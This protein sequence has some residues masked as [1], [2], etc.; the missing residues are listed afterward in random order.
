MFTIGET[1][2]L[3]DAIAARMSI[4]AFDPVDIDYETV[5]ELAYAASRAASRNNSQSWR[6]IFVKGKDRLY[7]LRETLSP[8]NYWAKR[9]SM[10]VAVRSRPDLDCR[11]GG[12]D[13]N[14]MDTGMALSQLLLSAV[15]LGLS[16]HPVAGFDRGKAKEVLGVPE[17]HQLPALVIVGKRSGDL[18]LLRKEW[19]I[20]A[21]EKVSERKPLEGIMSTDR[22]DFRDD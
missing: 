20:E 2:E 14:L 15:D 17:D 5:R 21:E 11:I 10:I 19:Q 12:I 8:G 16:V 9:A 6:F 4:R 3:M 1:V 22:F 13:Y 7:A 18:T